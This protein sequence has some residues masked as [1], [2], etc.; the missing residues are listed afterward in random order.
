M[1]FLEG[2]QPSK[3]TIQ[4]NVAKYQLKCTSLHL[5]KERPGRRVKKAEKQKTSEAVPKT[6]EVNIGRL[7]ARRNDL[8]IL[9]SSFWWIRH[10]CITIIR[11]QLYENDFEKIRQ[12]FQSFVNQCNNRRPLANSLIMSEAKFSLNG[13]LLDI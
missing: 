9:A 8:G 4:I 1:P 13:S 6:L 2:N 5:N 11:H 12:F 3:A 7:S 10:P